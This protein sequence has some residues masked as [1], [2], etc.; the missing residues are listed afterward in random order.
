MKT[1]LF[2]GMTNREIKR[3]MKHLD[4]GNPLIHGRIAAGRICRDRI[5]RGQHWRDFAAVWFDPSNLTE[6]GLDYLPKLP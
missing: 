3:I 6:K 2:Q 1:P 4:S 5:A